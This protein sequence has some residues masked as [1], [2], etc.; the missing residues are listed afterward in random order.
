MAFQKVESYEA[1]VFFD[2]HQICK[3][4]LYTEFEAILDGVVGIPEFADQERRVA[5]INISPTFHV[6]GCV[7]FTLSFG[8]QGDIS[9]SWNMPL[10]HLEEV[11]GTGP[12]LGAGPIRLACKSQCPIPW[13]QAQLW[14]PSLSPAHN[15]LLAIQKAVARNNLCLVQMD[16]APTAANDP[17]ANQAPQRS[18]FANGQTAAP[19]AMANH[20]STV[21]FQAGAVQTPQFSK[22]NPFH[23]P[24][25]AGQ[26]VQKSALTEAERKKVADTIRKQRLQISSLKSG[27]KEKI[28]ELQYQAKERETEL[29]GQLVQQRS[30]VASL[31]A[32]IE[33]LKEQLTA[34]KMQIE[35]LGVQWEK[36]LDSQLADKDTE[37]EHFKNQYKQQQSEQDN[38]KWA[39][40]KEQVQIKEMELIYRDEINKQLREELCELRRDKLRLVDGGADK[41][42][43][44]LDKIGVSFICYHPGAGHLSIP[45]EDMVDYIDDPIRYA[46]KKCMVSTDHYR[47]WLAHHENPICLCE[48]TPGNKCNDVVKRVEVPNQ[49]KPGEHDRC[50]KHRYGLVQSSKV[51]TFG[52]R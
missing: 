1:L 23:M 3:E 16:S 43:E 25:E 48:I 26:W 28:A 34:Q 40:L 33:A 51:V 12:D 10:R 41:F 31:Q 52:G 45:L 13:H 11:A 39:E 9:R 5:Y 35:A 29:N 36:K 17:S 24:T 14:D 50:E 6:T 4:M 22:N 37:I 42:L 8:S 30:M 2:G 15:D 49:F 7:L 21:N 32:Q 27:H 44:K 38:Q 46:A 20:W 19:A 18:N 47:R